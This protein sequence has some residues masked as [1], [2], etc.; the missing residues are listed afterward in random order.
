MN[1]VGYARRA[2]Q[3]QTV[4]VGNQIG[5]V[6]IASIQRVVDKFLNAETLSANSSASRYDTQ[7]NVFSQLSG[8]LG[9]PGDGTSLTSM[10]TNVGAA[11]GQAALSPTASASQIGALSAFQNLAGSLSN[12]GSAVATLRSQVDQ[13][14]VASTGTVNQLIKQIYDLNTQ[15]KDATSAG[16]DSSALLDQRDTALNNLAQLIGIRTAELPDGRTSVMTE[17][18]INLVGDSYAQLSYSGGSNNGTYNSIQIQNINPTSGLGIGP[19]QAFDPHLSGGK[20]KGLIDMRD[21]TL[22]DLGQEVGNLARQTALAYNTVNN[23]NASFPPPASMTGRNTGLDATDALNFTGD[24]TI[25]VAD[26][27][28]TMTSRIDVDFSAQTITLNG[29]A[30]TPFANTVGAFTTALNTVLGSNGSASFVNGALTLSANGGN[31]IVVQDDATTPANR[32]G[33]GFSQFFGLNDL[34]RGA[35]PSILATGLTAPDAGNFA[36]GS[37]ISL[38]LK[39]PN[40]DIARQ[41]TVTLT[42][43]MTIGQVVTALN[44]AMGGQVSFTLNSD[45][46]ISQTNSASTTN[47]A[48][49]V[50]NDTTQRG[51]TGMSFTQLFGIGANQIALQAQ[52]FAVNPRIVASPSNLAFAKPQLA[53]ALVGDSIVGHGD[54]SGAEALQAVGAANQTF[55]KAGNMSANVATLSD[56]AAGF[57]QDVATTSAAATSN[58]TAQD[59]RLQE[60]QTRQSATS[61]VNLDEELTHMMTY[62]QAYAAGARLLSVVGQ[63]Y[64]TLLQIQ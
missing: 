19:P 60:A 13:Q 45:G 46:S 62:Q 4:A 17:D 42:G 41:A 30:V 26:A 54:N 50:T 18:G 5:G 53:G 8:V 58:Q 56:Y 12:L 39:G 52:S 28:G 33:S 20:L 14:V 24:T 59:D 27:N 49:N 6:D 11:L 36:A 21:G 16:D 64:D 57:Y 31:G 37:Q 38:Q 10:L 48:L 51:T 15:V 47:Y 7:A 32:G 29:G 61:G 22:R 63:L 44:T 55:A 1:T 23:S 3:F 40:G 25:A 35:A 43:G 34:F 9:Q 2:V